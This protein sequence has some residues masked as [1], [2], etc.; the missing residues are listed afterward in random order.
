MDRGHSL[1]NSPGARQHLL[2]WRDR[3]EAPVVGAVRRG[4]GRCP[5]IMG[6]LEQT[7]AFPPGS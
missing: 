6:A 5:G 4:Q 3:E 1:C 7:W 2:C